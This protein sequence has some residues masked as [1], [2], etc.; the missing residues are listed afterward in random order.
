MGVVLTAGFSSPWL[1]TS[2]IGGLHS[3]KQTISKE[4][5][6]DGCDVKKWSMKTGIGYV[7]S[8]MPGGAAIGVALLES[9]ALKVGEFL[10]CRAA[11]GTFGG[12][13]PSL[14]SDASKKFVD[15]QNV[16]CKQ[17]MGHAAVAAT[18]GAVAATTGIAVTRAIGR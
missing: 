11:I 16:T 17:V 8:V 14:I 9:T 5:L 1:V 2:I 12:A 18:A 4:A 6:A 10:A 7:L 13:S 15:G 3:L